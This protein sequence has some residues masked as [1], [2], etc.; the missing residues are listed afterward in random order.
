MAMQLRSVSSTALL[1]VLGFAFFA[2]APAAATLIGLSEMS[3][4]QDEG[5]TPPGA[6]LA[7]LDFVVNGSTLELTVYNT[8]ANVYGNS[9]SINEV[10]FN[11]SD[12]V[13]GLSLVPPT[14]PDWRLSTNRMR[15]GFGTFDY[16]LQV[17]GNFNKSTATVQSG[18]TQT[19][20][21]EISCAVA[22]TCDM[23]DFAINNASGKAV[24]AKFVNGGEFFDE[25][26]AGGDDSAF[27]ASGEGFPPVPEPGTA[28][29]VAA[30]LIG[31]A[32]AGRR[33][34]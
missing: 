9:Y 5:G 4:E 11:T 32:Y 30:G 34:S 18:T 13:A 19:L 7:N 2:S 22:A 1:A 23:M 26:F 17:Q 12:D 15:N 14:D 20:Y 24:G 29:L 10:F 27:G 3:S 8:F 25:A 28:A 31:L 33:R 21:L 6:L 16:L